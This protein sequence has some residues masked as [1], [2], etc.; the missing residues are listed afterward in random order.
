MTPDV[1]RY[2]RLVTEVTSPGITRALASLDESRARLDREVEARVE[3][4]SE[5]LGYLARKRLL[6]SNTLTRPNPDERRAWDDANRW[7]GELLAR[8]PV[9]PWSV[10]ELVALNGVL[11]GT[12]GGVRRDPIYSCGQEYL[13]PAEVP[14]ELQAL[15]AHVTSTSRPPLLVAATLYIAV[16]T[17]HPFENG[18]GRTSRLAADRVLL[19]NG[20]LPVCFLSPIASHVA[21][22]QSGPMRDPEGCVRLVLA[23]IGESYATVFRRLDEAVA[24]PRADRTG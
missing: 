6:A 24:Q 7:L 8:D 10:S 11:T 17:I 16:V 9:P 20:Y 18:N 12:V 2:L 19:Q 14:V 4:A 15:E 21:Q 13:A 5:A 3:Q 22:M 1:S 23:A